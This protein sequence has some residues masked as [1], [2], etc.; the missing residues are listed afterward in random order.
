M[1]RAFIAGP[2]FSGRSDHLMALLRERAPGA[3]FFIGPYA[4]AALSGLSSTVADEI[5][6][7]SAR[8]SLARPAFL[9][10]DFAAYAARKPP[11]LSGGEQVLLALHCFSLSRYRTIGIDTAL[12]QLD[13]DNRALA[14][15]YLTADE[16]NG[17][18]VALIDN[19]PVD[20]WSKT[21][22]AS[23]SDF[24]CDLEAA[25][26]GLASRTAPTITIERLS[27]R[28]PKGRDIFTGVDLTLAPGRAYRLAGPN[29]AG[30]TTLFK[31][32]AGVLA[33]SS[34]ALARD[35]APYAPWRDGNRL[36]AFATQNPD[37]QWCG[38][39]L[40]EDVA[41]RRTALARHGIAALVALL[42]PPPPAPADAGIS[43]LAACLGVRSLD[44][45]LYELPLAARKRLSWLWPLSG[46]LPWIMLDEPTIGQDAATRAALAAAVARLCAFGHG[47]VFI[48]HDEEFAGLIDHQPLRLE[49]GAIAA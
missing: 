47:V 45:H 43:M 17:F 40:G 42:F 16:A 20:G 10:L 4:E 39:T 7:Y 8:P 46:T 5:D 30:K 35:G 41:R 44:A 1:A 24:A 12:E 23:T 11:T 37:H 6:I 48:T 3:A 32:L 36:F 19:R 34:G 31:L 49:R 28:Y 38:A 13:P 15:A 26:A 25:T 2:N 14:L 29:G 33:P 22:L 9:A 27:F 18:D 21:T